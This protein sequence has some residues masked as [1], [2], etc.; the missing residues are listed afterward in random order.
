VTGEVAAIKMQTERGHVV[1]GCPPQDKFPQIGDRIQ[2]FAGA[3][4]LTHV[5]HVIAET[6][7]ADWEE[8]VKAIFGPKH[9]A[10]RKHPKL[11][12]Q[13]FFSCTLEDD[14]S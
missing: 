10:N 1:I 13:R 9:P 6:D 14:E 5:L 7:R 12:G 11:P 2:H 3:F 4:L 8:Q